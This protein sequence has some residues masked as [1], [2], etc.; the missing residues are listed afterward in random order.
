MFFSHI[1]MFQV[2]YNIRLIQYNAVNIILGL[3]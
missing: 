3:L 2:H 1:N